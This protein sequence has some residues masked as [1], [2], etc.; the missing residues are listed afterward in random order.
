MPGWSNVAPLAVGVDPRGNASS[1]LEC[2]L[3]LEA[4][5]SSVG[6]GSSRRLRSPGLAAPTLEHV[7][8]S[9]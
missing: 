7:A 6:A 5:C 8:S 3:P 2:S 9:G 4:T 1:H